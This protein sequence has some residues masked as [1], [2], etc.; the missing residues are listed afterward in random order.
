MANWKKF[1]T[2]LAATTVSIVLTF[3]T[4]AIINQKKKNNEKRAMV[5]MIMYDMRESLKE[6]EECDKDMNDFFDLQVELIAHPQQFYERLNELYIHIPD[7]EYTTTA[8][9]I[10]R[11][12]IETINTIGNILFV[13]A[14]SSFYDNRQLYKDSVVSDFQRQAQNATSSYERLYGF[15]SA[16]YPFY[17]QAYLRRMK[18]RYELCKTM[19][20]VK[21]KDL[22][23][24]NL[25]RQKIQEKVSGSSAGEDQEKFLLDIQR[26]NDE[27]QKA[28]QEGRRAL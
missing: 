19:M 3:G 28:R 24:F 22:E 6:A 12:N 13:E 8:E 23:A 21:D 27:L 20:K 9:S 26:R 5:M 15:D 18:D 17:S 10:F 1:M 7:F 2:S 4:T 14:A 25:K 11:S 16:N